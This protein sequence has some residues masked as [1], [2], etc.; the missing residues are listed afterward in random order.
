MDNVIIPDNQ[1]LNKKIRA[2]KRAGQDSLHILSDFDRT[3]TQAYVNGKKIWSLLAILRDHFMLTRD[4]PAK[5]HALAD[6]YLPIERDPSISR[7]EKRRLMHEW[8]TK[9]FAL[10][11][12]SGLTK[13]D[14]EKALEIGEV[15]LRE[16]T[17]DLFSLANR[18]AIPLVIM[19][20]SGIGGDA[21]AMFLQKNNLLL[22]NIHVIGNQIVWDAHGRAT[23]V[24]EPII[25]SLN[26]D[27]TAIQ[28]FPVYQQIKNRKNVILLGDFADDVGMVKGFDYDNLITIGFLNEDTDTQLPEYE[29]HFDVIIT[30]DG[31]MDAVNELIKTS[32]N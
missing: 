4:Y 32:I 31:P 19:S 14:I 16:G 27:E 26:K 13:K 29:K 11:I 30:N 17:S 18:C 12:E 25:H 21:I 24:Q 28:N 8:W 3:L 10:L 9:H 20:A 23:G 1:R 6:T 15:M 5:A 7:D 2:I 22:P